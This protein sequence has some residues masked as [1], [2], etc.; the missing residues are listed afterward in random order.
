MNCQ[1][2]QYCDYELNKTYNWKDTSIYCMNCGH[3]NHKD[4]ILVTYKYKNK[5]EHNFYIDSINC[6]ECNFEITVVTA[7]CGGSYYF[8]ESDISESLLLSQE[9]IIRK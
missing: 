8:N 2:C 6:K 7:P 1:Y 3:N 4:E 5:G 9:F